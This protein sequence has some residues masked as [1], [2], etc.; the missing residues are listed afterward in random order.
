ML[1]WTLG[2]IGSVSNDSNCVTFYKR[3]NYK[4][5]EKITSFQ[6]LEGRGWIKHRGCLGQY[7]YFVE[8]CNGG[9]M[10]LY[11]DQNP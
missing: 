5:S 9:Y 1:Q 4:D 10:T 6:G 8:Y 2:C 7:S 3:Q 11:N